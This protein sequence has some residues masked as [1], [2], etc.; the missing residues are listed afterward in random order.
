MR[1]LIPGDTQH[2]TLDAACASGLFALDA[3]VKALR[4]GSCDV[5]LAGGT[6]VIEPIGFTLFCRAQG[7]SM[8]GRYGPSTGRPTGP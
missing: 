1:G 4:E 6:S 7:I 3:A 8:S 2:V 5:A